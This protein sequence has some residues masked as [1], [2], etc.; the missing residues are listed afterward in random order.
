MNFE[1][2]DAIVPAQTV[3]AFCAIR[4]GSGR[5]ARTSGQLT[6]N[7][8]RAAVPRDARFASDGHL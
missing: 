1:L 3:P 5:R 2:V 7:G 8:H 4:P 6:A